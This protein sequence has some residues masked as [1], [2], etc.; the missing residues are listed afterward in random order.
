ME[1]FSRVY[2]SAVIGF[3][4]IQCM[5]GIALLH[6]AIINHSFTFIYYIRLKIGAS[7]TLYSRIWCVCGQVTGNPSF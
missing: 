3:I 5:Y 1:M 6:S 7:Q 4:L 2:I